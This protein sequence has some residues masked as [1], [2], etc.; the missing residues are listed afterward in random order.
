MLIARE[1]SKSNS[2]L[3]A[4]SRTLVGE[5]FLSP[6][7][8]RGSRHRHF[9]ARSSLESE[10]GVGV[11]VHSPWP[12]SFGVQGR[13]IVNDGGTQRSRAN[14]ALVLYKERNRQE[15]RARARSTDHHVVTPAIIP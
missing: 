3:P 10:H 6:S 13:Q 15:N 12:L 8:P 9:R 1:S 2:A 14:N 11:L 7:P 5:L 4:G